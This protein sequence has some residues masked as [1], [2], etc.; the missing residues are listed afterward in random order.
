M[1]VHPRSI[2]D[3]A[4]NHRIA[5]PFFDALYNASCADLLDFT[6]PPPSRGRIKIQPRQRLQHQI[7][8]IKFQDVFS[9]LARREPLSVGP[10]SE[11]TSFHGIKSDFPIKDTACD[12]LVRDTRRK[13]R[14]RTHRPLSST[15]PR[16]ALTPVYPVGTSS[17][18]LDAF[19]PF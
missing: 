4:F 13:V 12:T 14:E 2:F 18:K 5:P 19:P 6:A 15:I 7:P 16:F 1:N 8:P 11:F 9:M 10:S 3:L 17:F